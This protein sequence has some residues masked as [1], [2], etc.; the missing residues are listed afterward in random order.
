MHANLSRWGEK[1]HNI[2]LYNTS[3]Y[4]VVCVLEHFV[5]EALVGDSSWCNWGV[6]GSFPRARH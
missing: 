6:E 1:N 4:C 3:L 5:Q 2:M